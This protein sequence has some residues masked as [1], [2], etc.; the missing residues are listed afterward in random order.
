MRSWF[1]VA[2]VAVFFLPAMV[3]ARGL[4]DVAG[5]PYALIIRVVM[6]QA[7]SVVS[8]RTLTDLTEPV[9]AK[10]GPYTT[11]IGCARAGMIQ[12]PNWITKH[13]PGWSFDEAYCVPVTRIEMFLAARQGPNI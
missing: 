6:V 3:M 9:G 10:E 13:L 2:L 5:G 12:V 4:G 11:Q 7:P 8:Y 1:A